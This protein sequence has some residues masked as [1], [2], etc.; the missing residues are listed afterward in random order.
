MQCQAILKSGKE[1]SRK[2]QPGSNFCWQH[3]NYE[4]SAT[5]AEGKEGE[6]KTSPRNKSKA[7]S[8]KTSPRNLSPVGT[9][10]KSGVTVEDFYPNGQ[11]KERLTY[12]DGTLK[13]LNGPFERWYKSGGLDMIGNYKNGK[14]DGLYESWGEMNNRLIVRSN[15]KNGELNGLYETWYPAGQLKEKFNFKNGKLDGLSELFYENGKL[16][17]QSNYKNGKL[18][19]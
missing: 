19:G 15:Y 17:S 1:C 12:K 6:I 9:Q 8:P 3:Q 13:I 2:A 5:H 7:I 10:Y 18:I 4:T 11:V 14:L 16:L